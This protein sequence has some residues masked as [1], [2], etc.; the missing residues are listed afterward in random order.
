MNVCLACGRLY[1]DE[2]AKC[3]ADGEDLL[4][5]EPSL[6][7]GTVVTGDVR[8]E[9]PIGLGQ[10]GEIFEGKAADGARVVVRLVAEELTKDKRNIDV[11]RRHLLKSKEFHHPSVVPIRAVDVREGRLVI[12]R[13]WVDGER[14]Q[15]LLAREGGLAVSR[16][17]EIAQRICAA[18]GDAH[19][20]GLLHLQVRASNVFLQAAE[21]KDE[22]RLVDFGLGPLRRVA[23]KPVYGTLRTMAPEQLESRVPSFKSDIF[24]TGVL[25][26]RMIAGSSPFIGNED[27]VAK[28]VLEAPL[29]P[30]RAIS[31][32]SLPPDLELLIKQMTDKKP[33]SR[34]TGMTAVVERLRKL[35]GGRASVEPRP[36]EAIAGPRLAARLERPTVVMS[37]ITS[38]RVPQADGAPA[39]PWEAVGPKGAQKPV[40]PQ[41]PVE[42]AKPVEPQKP[43]A[44]AATGS[45]EDL[46][47]SANRTAEVSPEEIEIA[48][49]HAPAG[50]PPAP[51]PRH[52]P[53]PAP[54]KPAAPLHPPT[55]PKVET[56][57]RPAVPAKVVEP[58]P[59]KPEPSRMVAAAAEPADDGGFSISVDETPPEAAA[60][61][62]LGGG[63]GAI[64]PA[65]DGDEGRPTPADGRKRKLIII[66]AAVGAVLLIVIL[67]FA[68]CGKKGTTA[69]SDAAVAAEDAGTDVV[70]A[71]GAPAEV[72]AD[73]A[74]VAAA[75][76]E[77]AQPDLPVDVPAEDVGAEAEAEAEADVVE[78]AE[79]EAEAEAEAEM[80]DAPT[81]AVEDVGAEAS[82]T[83]EG[84]SA[85]DLV[86]AA[87]RAL[88]A[89][90]FARAKTLFQQA[91]RL[92]PG[93]NRA[94]AGLGRVAFQQG[95]F[96]EAVRYLEP[97]YRSQGN[98]DLGVAYVR[99]G[100][101]DDARRQFE[102]LLDRNPNNADARRALD[103]LNR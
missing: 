57:A 42:A 33:A 50:A 100:R 26:Y 69:A 84:P 12:V 17:V 47:A 28:H 49:M 40:E 66:G 34:P 36:V 9:G 92:E 71:A 35:P 65:K 54:V 55:K 48:P 19:R 25:I 46:E 59:R 96:A 24:S 6:E 97:V 61:A 3:P 67:M 39:K 31:G 43:K 79:V 15:D 63:F 52:E 95:Q 51:P 8:I 81:D 88:A 56:R 21:E 14:L 101:V 2:T 32:E 87:N 7:A 20:T 86:A 85:G 22:I 80:G 73:V 68:F 11:L 64:D 93:N 70:D 102:R 4:P 98:M 10:C 58:K 90:E 45:Y 72:E 103:A 75:T 16:A 30:L 74:D 89:R 62:V 76:E 44:A 91:L 38:K 37:A 78:E 23:G 29:P 13:D 77:A 83:R 53:A 41:K 27:E 99:V 94:R 60:P 1:D 18:L 5:H 82:A